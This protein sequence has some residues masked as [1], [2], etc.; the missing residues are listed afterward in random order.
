MTPGLNPGLGVLRFGLCT[1]SFLAKQYPAKKTIGCGA[2]AA[3]GTA[4]SLNVFCW[5]R[6]R[7][8]KVVSDILN[9][10]AVYKIIL[11]L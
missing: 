4:R 5:G 6:S 7:Y 8:N 11:K 1:A 3:A 10:T 9:Y 2:L